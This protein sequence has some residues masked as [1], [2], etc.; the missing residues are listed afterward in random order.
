[1]SENR[2][3]YLI[4]SDA[5]SAHVYN[6]IKHSLLDRGFEIYILRHSIQDIPEQYLNFYNENNI[7]YGKIVIEKAPPF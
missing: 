4:I 7:K 3:K 1:M 2:K 6:F 5:A